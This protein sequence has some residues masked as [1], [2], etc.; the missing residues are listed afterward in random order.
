M[1]RILV[2]SVPVVGHLNPLVPIVRALCAR[3]HEVRWYTGAKYRKKVEAAGARF[4]GMSFARDYDDAFID[5]E[6][7]GRTKLSGLAKLKYDMK[8]VFI[9][10]GEG[11]LLDIAAIARDFEPD[12][13]LCEAGCFG[14]VFYSEQSGVPVA[15]LGVIPLAR[16]SIDTAPFGLG[17]PPDRSALGHLRN[18]VLNFAIERVLFR[19]VQAHW[20]AS[21]KR[22]GLPPTQWWLNAGERATV[23]LQPTIPELEH[24]RSDLPANVRFI[25]LI[26]ADPP[27]DWIAPPWFRELDGMRPIVHVTQGTI[28]N[29]A[30]DLIAPALQGLANEN[31]VV[32]VATGGRSAEALGLTKMPANAHIADFLSYAELLPK[33]SV[34]VTNGGYGGV[35]MAL[36]Q[37]VPVVV[38]GTTEDKPEVAARVASAGAGI[39]LKTSTPKPEQVRTAVRMLLDDRRYRDR[40]MALAAEYARYDAISLAVEAVEDLARRGEAK[41]E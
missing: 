28:A 40:A 1:A 33:I 21:R 13:L 3:G 5:R 11:Q 20:N 4:V 41:I 2:G 22:V 19:D 34:F 16:S 14:T 12:A 24:Y 9:D 31:V 37:G 6:F 30:P 23:Y 29:A 36:A 35:Q 39:N 15:L 8:H 18:R 10:N 32:V 17:L 25:G 38:A 27:R 26:P 7:P